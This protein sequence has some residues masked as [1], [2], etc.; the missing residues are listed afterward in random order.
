MLE[1]HTAE[2]RSGRGPSSRAATNVAW[3]GRGALVVDVKT[4]VTILAE[5]AR[6]VDLASIGETWLAEHLRLGIRAADLLEEFG[7]PLFVGMGG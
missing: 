2:D 5:D 1:S 6:F 4:G 3:Y 7:E